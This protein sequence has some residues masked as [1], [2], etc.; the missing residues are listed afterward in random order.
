[1]II[2]VMNVAQWNR[3]QMVSFS[4]AVCLANVTNPKLFQTIRELGGRFVK[5]KS[6]PTLN[7]KNMFLYFY[8][9][10]KAELLK[11]SLSYHFHPPL[12]IFW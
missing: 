9:L 4:R 10:P 11:R 1:M 12:T 3:K 2:L 6:N 8:T 5:T 7:N